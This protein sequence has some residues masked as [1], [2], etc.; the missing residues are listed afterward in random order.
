MNV[1]ALIN[2]CFIQRMTLSNQRRLAL[3]MS[4]LGRVPSAHLQD[5]S[6]VSHARELPLF[7][8]GV[9]HAEILPVV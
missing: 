1:L 5:R 2:G 7:G 4:L 6:V 3:L 8:F 9:I